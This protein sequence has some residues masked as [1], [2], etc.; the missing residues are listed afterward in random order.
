MVEHGG[1]SEIAVFV[2]VVAL[3]AVVL[4]VWG[5]M[6]WAGRRPA[7]GRW[8]AGSTPSRCA[9]RAWVLLATG[10]LITIVAVVSA[11][12]TTTRSVGVVVIALALA[13]V[14]RTYW[15]YGTQPLSR[16]FLSAGR[17]Y[18]SSAAGDERVAGEQATTGRVGT[19]DRA[20]HPGDEHRRGV[21]EHP[22]P[23]TRHV[24][25]RFHTAPAGGT[26]RPFEGTATGEIDG[27][28]GS[29]RVVYLVGVAG[30][31]NLGDELITASWL[32]ELAVRAPHARVWV[33]CP[34]PGTA[35]VLLDGLHPNARFV[36]TLWRLCQVAPSDEPWELVAW[37]RHAVND[38][39]LAPRWAAGI[40]L[41]RTVDVIH[42]IGGGYIHTS[43]PRHHG[44]LAAAATI[45]RRFGARAVLTGQG[46]TPLSATSTALVAA[47]TDGFEVLDVRD[48]PSGESL[49]AAGAS[50]VSVTVDDAFLTL[51]Q[52]GADAASPPANL[53]PGPRT[54]TGAGAG[55]RPDAG[56]V[57]EYMLCAQSDMLAL[58][59]AELASLVL[60]TLAA[61]KVTP[62]NLGIVEGVPRVDREIYA[63][64]EHDLPGARFYP[65]A[66]IWRNGLPSA[67]GQ[68][69]IST[70]YH[71]HLLAAAS[72]ASGVAIP[73]SPDYYHTKHA[74]LISQG[75]RWTLASDLTTPPPR[76]TTGGFTPHTTRTHHHTKLALAQRIYGPP[77]PPN[78]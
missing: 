64:L 51:G 17:R 72:G 59:R 70:R 13:D 44:L 47:L 50:E 78:L 7:L 5:A 34:N 25:Q 4:L 10:T 21:D 42:L 43:W 66:E 62:D 76:P 39:G 29:A 45:T 40:E 3:A 74:S 54:A 61:W 57:P 63:L 23:V 48:E 16:R 37:V 36:D 35:A 77:T 27:T 33:D 14:G 24:T 75:S 69:W 52:P 1:R 32:R 67:P 22:G 73:I 46:L 38:P 71:P 65:F 8:P 31:P 53:S 9:G 12:D 28:V 56:A 20:R 2:R 19:G 15:R 18:R 30:Y 6:G 68:T 41:L 49:R 26:C 55:H 11:A 58:D 60:A